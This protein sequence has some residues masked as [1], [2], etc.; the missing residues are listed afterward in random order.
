MKR[1]VGH[2]PDLPPHLVAAMR[3][4]PLVTFGI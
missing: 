2:L 4:Q 3:L 1:L